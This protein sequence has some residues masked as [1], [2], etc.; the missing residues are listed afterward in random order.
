MMKPKKSQELAYQYIKEK[1][2]SQEWLPDAHI[3]EQD[4][5]NTL[6]L[7]RTPVRKAFIRLEEEGLVAKEPHRGIRIEHPTL[8]QKDFQNRMEFLELMINHYL[9]K[10]QVEETKLDAEELRESIENM[11]QSIRSDHEIFLE[12][13]LSYWNKLLQKESN[14]Y[15]SGMVLG[16]FR[17]L[18]SQKGHVQ[19]ILSQSKKDKVKHLRQLTKYIEEKN[20][21]YARR[22]IRILFNQLL[23]NV[24]QGV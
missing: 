9:H 19:K 23:L 21:P 4:V 16:T 8:S 11:E 5:A 1:I 10:L 7:S 22:E 14:T 20:Y 18:Y 6:E 15:S 3:R 13:E 12:K 17:S 24:I 2:M